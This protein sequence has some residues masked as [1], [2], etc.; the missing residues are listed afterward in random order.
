MDKDICGIGYHGDSERRKVIAIRIGGSMPIHYQWFI[1]S[2]PIGGN[3]VIPLYDGD[4]YIMSEK[5]VGFDWKS[6]ARYTLRHAAGPAN[7]TDIQEIIRK[8]DKLKKSK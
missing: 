2:R 4:L 6:N 5:A 8:K 1:K 3:V 7:F